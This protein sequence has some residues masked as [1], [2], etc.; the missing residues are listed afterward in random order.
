MRKVRFVHLLTSFSLIIMILAS[1][2]GYAAQSP[3]SASRVDNI[4]IQL[5][6]SVWVGYGPLFIALNKGYFADQGIDVTLTKVADPKERF[7]A[8]AGGK[9]DGLVSTLDT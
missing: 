6:Y 9:L 2:H 1:A 5:G 3:A 8:L 7:T 4:K